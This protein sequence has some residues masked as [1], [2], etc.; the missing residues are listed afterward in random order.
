MKHYQSIPHARKSP[1]MN[2]KC[3]GFVKYDGS[4]LRFEW[5]SKRGWYK[6]GTRK[7]LFDRTSAQFGS[8]IDLFL[9]KYG[10]PLEQ[11]FR[12]HKGLRNT[13]Q[14]IV[15]CEWFGSKSFAGWHEPGDP[16]TIVLFDVN[17]HKKGMLGPKEFLDTFG[18]LEVAECLWTGHVDET[19]L[20]DVRLGLMDVASK[21]AIR[22][23]I[24]EGLVFKSG[25]KHDLWM[26]KA[27]TQMW[28]DEL[29]KRH[30]IDWEKI[31]EMV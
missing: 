12:T 5:S 6:F 19:L 8:A 20:E 13:Q 26:A 18:H 1:C 11:I 4:N 17:I 21:Y 15:F 3:Y 7:L 28:F 29:K 30:P 24:P 31:E 16:K 10:S 27:K 22:T 14:A 23:A 2:R 9:N 25:N